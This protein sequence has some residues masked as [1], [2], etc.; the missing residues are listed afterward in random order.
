MPTQPSEA[1]SEARARL[2]LALVGALATN[3]P[4]ACVVDPD[5]GWTVLDLLSRQM[6]ALAC[7][8]CPIELECADAGQYERYGTWG[9]Q[10]RER[11]TRK[12]S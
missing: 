7:R 2:Q 4:P 10:N 11:E 3:T 5:G 12:D 1:V 9:G 8:G 6:A